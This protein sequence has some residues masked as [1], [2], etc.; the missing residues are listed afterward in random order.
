[1]SA[2]V[3]DIAGKSQLQEFLS[4]AWDSVV[5]VDFWANRC[6]PCR[7]LWPVLHAVADDNAGAVLV[8]KIDVD[9]PANQQL[10]IEFNVSSIPQVTIFK[11]GNQV[12][13]F[14]GALPQTDVQAKIAAYLS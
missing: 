9:N 6:G 2:F 4:Q 7:I 12:D 14:V 5:L 13:G 1:M 8:A 11:W 10:A 3:R